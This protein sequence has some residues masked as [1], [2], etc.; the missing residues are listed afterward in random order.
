MSEEIFSLANFS[1]FNKFIVVS[2]GEGVELQAFFY[3]HSFVVL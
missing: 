2:G 3:Y 1:S